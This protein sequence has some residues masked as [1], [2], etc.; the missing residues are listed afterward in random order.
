MTTYAAGPYQG[1]PALV[2]TRIAHSR[3]GPVPHSFTY[4]SVSWLI[5]ADRP[6]HLPR[7]LRAFADF[8]AA[9]HFPSPARH[10][11][12]LRG[13]LDDHLRT[14]GLEPPAGPVT[15]LLSPRVAGYVFN[16]LSVF[17]CHHGNGS[18]ALV[19]AEVHNTYGER[20]CYIVHPDPT[21]RATVAKEFYVSPFNE[22]SGTYQLRVPEPDGLGRVAVSVALHRDGH[23]PFIATLTGRASPVTP[24]A[25][26]ATQLR[27]PLAPLMV[28][29]RIRRQGIALW[30]KGL[31]L[32]PR[33]PQ[34]LPHTVD[35]AVPVGCPGAR[36]DSPT[37]PLPT[38][39]SR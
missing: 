6:P 34:H 38:E 24:A 4:R 29:A 35:T 39:G 13:R 23:D 14:A 17:W 10:G 32:V 28:A 5:D 30:L 18:L 37:P 33:P 11:D 19:V 9:D 12:T 31:P 22:V 7:P 2:R 21:G 25:V 26:L 20:H 3:S 8:R 1:T 16:P 36:S 27:A 15:A